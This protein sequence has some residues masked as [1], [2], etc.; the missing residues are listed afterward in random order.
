MG[1]TIMVIDDRPENLLISEKIL[2]PKY[3]VL[4]YDNGKDAV[5]YLFNVPMEELPDLI[6]LDI[7]M[8]E[9]DGYEVIR[10]IKSQDRLKRIPIICVT[11]SDD[12]L[13]ALSLGADDFISK[14]FEPEVVHLRVS[15]QIMLK[16]NMDDL[17]GMVQSKIDEVVSTRENMMFVMAD[18][19]EYRS[20]ET[21]SH[22]K[23]VV[24]YAAVLLED[25][26]NNSVYGKYITPR[27]ERTITRA[28]AIHDVGKIGIPDKILLKPG[29]LTEEEFEI[30][31]THTTIGKSIVD[32][33][34]HTS[35]EDSDFLKHCGDITL[36]HHEKYDGSGYPAGLYGD[37]IPL[38]AR[39]MA[40]CD[41]Y[42]A[43]VTKRVYK[44]SM[45]H[46]EARDIIKKGSGQHFDPV[47]VN[48]FLNTM[49]EFEAISESLP[50][51]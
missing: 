19:I 32:S 13:K 9:M 34:L 43:L 22:V 45:K 38:S 27:K 1:S 26:I 47:L 6:L 39:I 50:L 21:G 44:D 40:V 37:N 8:P 12:E 20:I 33:V 18:I 36:H 16:K 29:P 48:S 46:S 49:D 42:D 7:I 17:S 14:P 3:K 15:N 4:S 2:T 24:N 28:V 51:G 5:E 35:D 31:K 11:V 10:Q 41:V 30:M 25:L 23:R